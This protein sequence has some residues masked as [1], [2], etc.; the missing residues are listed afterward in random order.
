MKYLYTHFPT[1]T[2]DGGW[3]CSVCRAYL[4]TGEIESEIPCYS[5]PVLVDEDG[6]R[7][8]ISVRNMTARLLRDG[9]EVPV[10]ERLRKELLRCVEEQGALN[11]SGHYTPSERLVKAVRKEVKK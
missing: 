5:N 4:P 7:W 2:R 6:H 11:R 10:P 3:R 8:V 9:E 1:S